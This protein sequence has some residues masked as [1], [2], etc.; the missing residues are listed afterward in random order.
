[1]IDVNVSLSRWPFRRIHGDEPQDLVAGLRKRGVKQAWTGSFDAIFH[2]DMAGANSRLAGD[3]RRFG[4]GTLIP[5]GSLNPKLPDW[6]EDFRRCHEEH[7]MPGIRVYPNYHGYTIA[8]PAFAELLHL[9]AEH[10]MILEIALSMEDERTQN[11]LM[12]V[13]NVDISGLPDLLKKEP[14]ARVILLNADHLHGGQL[15]DKLLD[16]GDV[17]FDLSMVESV[18]GVARLAQKVSV[19]RIL[20]GSNYPLYYFESALLKVREAGFTA[21]DKAAVLERNALRLRAS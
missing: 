2:K 18:G 5:F 3:C 9:A 15:I 14:K 10:R 8:D 17:C 12:R 11:P 1:M 7:R 20:F 19:E 13:P 4:Q 6:Q 21:G 16:A